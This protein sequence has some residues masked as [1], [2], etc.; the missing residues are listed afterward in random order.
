MTKNPAAF[1]DGLNPSQIMRYSSKLDFFQE[2]RG[3]SQNI[4]NTS[5]YLSPSNGAGGLEQRV[6]CHP[7]SFLGTKGPIM[8]VAG[9]MA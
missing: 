5:L 1:S 8:A 2:T 6:Q 4:S 7:P 3:I 9:M